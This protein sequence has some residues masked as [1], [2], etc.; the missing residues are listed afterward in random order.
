MVPPA[1]DS[2]VATAAPPRPRRADARRNIEAI[3][4]AATDLLAVH[5]RASMQEIAEAAGVH[6][7]TV[8]RHFPGRD[9]LLAA[10]HE[11]ALDQTY[12]LLTDPA[13]TGGDPATALERLTHAVL[14]EGDARRTWRIAP[15]FAVSADR[16][17]EF[18]QPLIALFTRGL[19]A[20]AV[21]DD[22]DPRSLASVWGGLVLSQ[23]NL[24]AA[25]HVDLEQ[26]T[27]T[28]CRIL[29]RP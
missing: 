26:A 25:G 20:G 4:D 2:E 14:R 1:M 7:A 17:P 12:A 19:A 8:H 21:R 23:L 10:M 11:R 13:L 22:V 5:P 3:L 15:P 24:L 16:G 9:D 29:A 6:R 28:I 18:A 27:A